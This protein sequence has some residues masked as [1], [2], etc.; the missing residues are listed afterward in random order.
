MTVNFLCAV[1]GPNINESCFVGE[2]LQDGTNK[3]FMGFHAETE[4][5]LP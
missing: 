2:Y 5:V 1:P 3:D 4:T